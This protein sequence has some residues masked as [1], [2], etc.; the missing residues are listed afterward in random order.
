MKV[1]FAQDWT[2]YLFGVCSEEAQMSMISVAENS[3]YL[4]DKADVESRASV[5]TD[6]Q[7]FGLKAKRSHKAKGGRRGG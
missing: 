4:A 6:A 1:C 5:S 2:N 3:S 7:F